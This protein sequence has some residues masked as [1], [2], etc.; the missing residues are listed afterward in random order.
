MVTETQQP[1]KYDPMK[2]KPNQEDPEIARLYKHYET[3]T[4][5]RDGRVEMK[6]KLCPVCGWPLS[7][8]GD[9]LR[10]RRE[11]CSWEPAHT[12]PK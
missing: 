1:P 6:F 5:I 8:Q 10:K 9:D 3:E 4:C 12:P 11:A 7:L 2:N